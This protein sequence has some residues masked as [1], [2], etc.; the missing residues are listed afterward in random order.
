MTPISVIKTDVARSTCLFA[1]FHKPSKKITPAEIGINIKP[2][3]INSNSL[4]ERVSVKVGIVVAPNSGWV[5]KGTK[6]YTANIKNAKIAGKQNVFINA[7]DGDT[8]I[9]YKSDANPIKKFVLKKG[10]T[11]LVRGDLVRIFLGNINVARVFLDNKPL[12]ITSRSGVKS[13]VFP[14]EK[15]SEFK[16][17]LFIYNSGKAITSSEYEETL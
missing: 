8:W 3:T 2:L 13:L 10:R 15:A 11:L 9:T 14:Q 12:T 4:F 7:V 5:T 16:L 1:K 6:R 17:P